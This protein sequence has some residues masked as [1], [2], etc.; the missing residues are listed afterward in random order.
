MVVDRRSFRCVGGRHCRLDIRD[1]QRIGLV[2]RERWIGLVCIVRNIGRTS[3]SRR[4]VDVRRG[5]RGC[6]WMIVV[7]RGVGGSGIGPARAAGGWST[8]G[9]GIAWLR[10]RRTVRVIQILGWP[11]RSCPHAR[12]GGGGGG[13][14]RVERGLLGRRNGPRLR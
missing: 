9:T 12:G 5:R 6:R 3:I 13:R 10:T 4:R 7:W 11:G 1:R 8:A 14:Q 2:Q